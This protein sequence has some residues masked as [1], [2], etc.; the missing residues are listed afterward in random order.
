[1]STENL[2][3]PQAPGI[4][5]QHTGLS[6][7]GAYNSSVNLEKLFCDGS[8]VSDTA[9]NAFRSRSAVGVSVIFVRFSGWRPG[10]FA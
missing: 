6:G 10:S 7:Q 5:R 4:P 8:I 1:M 2:L 3:R 9:E